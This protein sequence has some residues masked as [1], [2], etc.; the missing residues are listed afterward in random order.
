[1]L[2]NQPK[3]LELMD[4]A[5]NIQL[6]ADDLAIRLG[7]GAY[8]YVLERA[9]IARIMGDKESAVTWCDIALAIVE[10][11]APAKAA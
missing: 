6:V 4:Q 1:M 10:V 2:E 3:V 8:A 5:E 7:I 11:R 9:E